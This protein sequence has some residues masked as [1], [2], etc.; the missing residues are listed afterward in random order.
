MGKG[1]CA[2]DDERAANRIFNARGK[3]GDIP[4]KE[5]LGA[6]VIGDSPVLEYA[7]DE[8]AA[9]GGEIGDSARCDDEP[10]VSGQGAGL[11]VKRFGHGEHGT[12]LH[13]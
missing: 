4:A 12:I 7:V 13:R 1:P 11:P 8:F 2:L 3:I 5:D 9:G 6:G 10:A